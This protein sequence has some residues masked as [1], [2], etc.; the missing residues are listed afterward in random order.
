MVHH[1]HPCLL[2]LPELPANHDLNPQLPT[3][4]QSIASLVYRERA[5]WMWFVNLAGRLGS[6]HLNPFVL[7]TSA[8]LQRIMSSC[9]VQR[10]G[11]EAAAPSGVS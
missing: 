7:G 10:R 6:R 9:M 2:F 4:L 3:S 5:L 1:I 11:L 8:T